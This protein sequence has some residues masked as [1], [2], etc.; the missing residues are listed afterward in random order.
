LGTLDLGVEE[1]ID[2]STETAFR[3]WFANI[4]L[5]TFLKSAS[6]LRVLKLPHLPPLPPP[7]FAEGEGEEAWDRRLRQD[8]YLSS[9]SLREL[10]LC[11]IQPSNV[12]YLRRPSDFPSL[13]VLRVASYLLIAPPS[14]SVLRRLV[15][16]LTEFPVR[17][18]TTHGFFKLCGGHVF[19]PTGSVTLELLAALRPLR[20]V[21]ATEDV[22]ELELMML[23]DDGM[24][25]LVEIF[26]RLKE[27]RTHEE[28]LD[29]GIR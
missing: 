2:S 21:K 6:A 17:L 14:P 9:V 19:R 18:G 23:P 7:R 26:P 11:G 25:I 12:F 4:D 13:R 27:L 28:G 24:R 8:L 5:R 1:D 20:M 22:E 16:R 29:D 10:W 15:Q 3:I